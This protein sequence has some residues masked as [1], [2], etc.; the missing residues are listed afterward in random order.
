MAQL[1]EAAD[2]G[3]AGRRVE[4][5]EVRVESVTGDL[6]FWV[7]SPGERTLIVLDE[8]QQPEQA[9]TIRPGQSVSITGMARPAPPENVELSPADRA[10]L[11]AVTLYVDADHVEVEGD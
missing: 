2:E 10:A 4:L 1:A 3:L 6:T 5:A 9:V 8:G 7:G 11:D